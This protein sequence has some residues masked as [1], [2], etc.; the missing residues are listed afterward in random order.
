MT[1]YTVVAGN[2]AKPIR[3]IEQGGNPE[4]R[5]AYEIQERNERVKKRM[6]DFANSGFTQHSK[7]IPPPVI[8]QKQKQ[9]ADHT[10][11]PRLI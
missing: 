7:S 3:R 5:H 6:Q 4:K 9:A 11:G 8:R 2:P 10:A 1:E